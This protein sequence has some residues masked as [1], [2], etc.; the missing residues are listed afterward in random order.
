MIRKHIIMIIKHQ[1][2]SLLFLIPG[3]LLNAQEQWIVEKAETKAQLNSIQMIDQNYGWIVCDNGVILFKDKGR[4][5]LYPKITEED[6][7]AVKLNHIGSGWAVGEGGMILKLEGTKWSQYPSPTKA[8][9]YDIDF[10]DSGNGIAVGD[11]GTVLTYESGEWNILSGITAKGKFY[12]VTVR[13]DMAMVAG[14]MEYGKVPVIN[15]QKNHSE[16]YTESFDPGYI[17]IRDIALTNGT[18]SFAVGTSGT[19]LYNDGMTW[20]RDKIF[21]KIPTLNSVVFLNEND[22]LAVGYFGTLLKY[23]G[24]GWKK[25]KV[26]VKTGL[27]G[28]SI[29]E[30]GY[31][32]VGDNGTILSRIRNTNKAENI[33]AASSAIQV[34]AYPNPST[35]LIKIIIPQE[36]DFVAAEIAITNGYGQIILNNVLDPDLAGQVYRINTSE[37][38]DGL[39]MIRITSA[40]RK[41]A[42]GKFIVKH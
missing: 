9:L 1:I 30:T 32:A 27:Y 25:E 26:P 17:E 24:T 11:H 28:A 36:D 20:T 37:M 7:Y 14:G 15:I 8:T 38:K 13:D 29:C 5:V 6:L 39:Y 22:G 31:Y 12:C 4:W 16:E 35:D 41:T 19:I 34:E 21:N 33:D 23:S 2:L 10:F 42:L 3:I 40:N 18:S